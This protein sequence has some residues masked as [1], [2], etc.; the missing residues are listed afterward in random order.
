M[1][2]L[3]NKKIAVL[4]GG[5][6]SER[7]VSLRSA[8]SVAAG[9]R[10]AGAAEV[11]PVD[12]RDESFTLPADIDFA[13]NMIHGTLGE[14]GRLQEILD[15]RGVRL[16][17]EGAAA[18]RLAFDKIL[19]KERFV[20]RGVKTPA[21]E[22]I[23][24]GQMPSLP[25]P[26]VIKAPRQGSSVGI[27]LCHNAD[28][29]AVA[30]REVAQFGDDILIEQLIVGAELTVGVLGSEALPIIMIRPKQGF[31]DY[32]NKYPWSNPA[33]AADHF[34]P[35]PISPELTANVQSLA[36]AAHRA[37]DLE[38]YSRVDILLTAE[39]EPFV[40][41][42]NTIPGMTESSLLPEAAKVAGI[43]MPQLLERIAELSLAR[44]AHHQSPSPRR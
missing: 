16:T 38:T 20:Q 10:A 31:Y 1:M 13:F 11:I 35:A 9:L 37:L 26:F 2:T 22:T 33:G 8:A 7:E 4:Q 17:G 34:C 12:V 25:L 43:E 39:G 29:V 5:P 6:G 44:Y 32:K 28:E 42:L 21:Y 15:A 30:L 41:E 14:D 3:A 23:R 24:A 19:S 36:L 18:S 40:L 27:Y